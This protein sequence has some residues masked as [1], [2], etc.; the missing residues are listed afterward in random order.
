M[1]SITEKLSFYL[2]ILIILLSPY[3]RG[4]YPDYYKL[5][6]LSLIFLS[7]LIFLLSRLQQ[8]ERFFSINY[9]VMS[10]FLLTVVYLVTI[11]TASSKSSAMVT[12]LSYVAWVFLFW[13]VFEIFNKETL[14]L[15]LIRLMVW[16]ASILSLLGI[17]GAFNLIQERFQNF[18]GMS[19]WG[20]YF[21]GRLATTFQYQNTSASFF[22]ASLFLG[23]FIFIHEKNSGKKLVYGI[24][25]FLIFF[26]F[27]FAF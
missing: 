1:T 15:F 12:F 21:S 24:L 7:F 11:I 5:P 27:L 3:Y 20:L 25:L 9:P 10:L 18:L 16:N 22:A 6:F 8:K 19:F 26:G 23:I 17:L 2:V 14:K 4:I 13:M